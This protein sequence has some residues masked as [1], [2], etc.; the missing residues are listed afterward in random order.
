MCRYQ[1]DVNLPSTQLP[2]A[3]LAYQIGLWLDAQFTA[4]DDKSVELNPT[5]RSWLSAK[6]QMLQ[7]INLQGRDALTLVNYLDKVSKLAWL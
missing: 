5:L 6:E 2:N 3:P 7:L 1:L 4:P